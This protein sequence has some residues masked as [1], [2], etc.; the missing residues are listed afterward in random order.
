MEEEEIMKKFLT[1]AVLLTNMIGFTAA[2]ANDV[3]VYS[4]HKS[5][6]DIMLTEDNIDDLI[7]ND[8]SHSKKHGSQ[9]HAKRIQLTDCKPK[10]TAQ[11]QETRSFVGTYQTP[12]CCLVI[13][14]LS[15]FESQFPIL[16]KSIVTTRRQII[17]VRR[18]SKRRRTGDLNDK[19]ICGNSYKRCDTIVKLAREL[20]HICHKYISIDVSDNLNTS[21]LYPESLATQTFTVTTH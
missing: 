18:A 1:T 20:I 5:Q 2:L 12:Q 11:N 10:S 21:D 6:T 3:T 7:N 9:K 4:L 17:C 16:S 15:V 19:K 14:S 8:S 13:L